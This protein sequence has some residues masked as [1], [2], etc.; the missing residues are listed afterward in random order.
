MNREIIIYIYAMNGHTAE[1][2]NKSSTTIKNWA[3][4]DRPREKLLI[5]GKEALSD[6]ELLA[7]L[8]Q[9][10]SGKKT[11]VD[12]AK[13]ILKLCNHNLGELS[14]QSLASLTRV[15]GVGNAKAISIVAAMEL[16]RR[17]QAAPSANQVIL[18]QS[19]QVPQYLHN[20]LRDH[21]REVFLVV[22]LNA[23]NKVLH[24][25]IVS[26]GGITGVVVDPRLIFHRALELKSVKIILCH[27]HPSGNLNPSR[28]DEFITEKLVN[29]GKLLDI[30]VADHI[31]VGEEGYFSFADN[32]RM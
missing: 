7:I 4:D 5:K 21:Q 18:S 9:T 14:K 11:A 16:G 28:Q 13:E 23:R 8:L 3:P 10:G 12:L 32:G 2:S 20:I 25:E 27:N 19:F 22:F 29:A 1:N 17:R 26:T 6:S 31:I 15:K 24:H 30:E